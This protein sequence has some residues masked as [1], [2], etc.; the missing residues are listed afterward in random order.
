MKFIGFIS[1]FLTA[2]RNLHPLT[3]FGYFHAFFIAIRSLFFLSYFFEFFIII[4][5]GTHNYVGNFFNLATTGPDV[6][7][8]SKNHNKWLVGANKIQYLADWRN[9]RVSEL[10]WK[11]K[12]RP[13]GDPSWSIA[14]NFQVH[15]FQ[16]KKQQSSI[17]NYLKVVVLVLI[18]I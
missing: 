2:Q 15:S 14:I 4:I 17:L 16:Q 9:E 13:S 3:V 7:P 8:I 6:T 10:K 1:Q 18:D 12:M 5:A 11:E